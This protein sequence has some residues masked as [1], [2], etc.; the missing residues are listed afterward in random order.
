MTRTLPE[1]G[2]LSLEPPS[3]CELRCSILTASAQQV[4][5]PEAV[6][7]RRVRYESLFLDPPPFSVKRANEAR[8]LECILVVDKVGQV[9]SRCPDYLSGCPG[10]SNESLGTS[11]FGVGAA[12]APM[13]DSLKAF[14]S[15]FSSTKPQ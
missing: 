10:P 12:A 2:R 6:F 14:A 4:A 15:A 3:T 9:V 5:A 13:P 1:K 11:N 7:L 8:C